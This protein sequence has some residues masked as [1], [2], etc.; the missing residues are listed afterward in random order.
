MDPFMLQPATTT[1]KDWVGTAAA[2]NSIVNTSLDLD[3]LAGLKGEDSLIL[4]VD[5]SASS[6]GAPPDWDVFVYAVER[7]AHG[8]KSFEDLERVEAERGSIPVK[9]ILLH[10]VSLEDVVRC[11][12]VVHFQLIHPEFQK[13]EVVERGDYPEQD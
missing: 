13:L 4:A 5:I 10:N 9:E 1:Y 8:I 12:K 2:E 11:M 6:H 7:G 3:E